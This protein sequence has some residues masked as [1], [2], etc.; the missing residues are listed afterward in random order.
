MG[1]FHCGTRSPIHART[2]CVLGVWPGATGPLQG[3]LL[4][5]P[6]CSGTSQYRCH[7]SPCSHGP[8]CCT[9]DPLGGGS[10]AGDW[11]NTE[12]SGAQPRVSLA[13]SSPS[14]AVLGPGYLIPVLDGVRCAAS[15]FPAGLG[16]PGCVCA[17]VPRLAVPCSAVRV[18]SGSG[19]A[20]SSPESVCGP[21]LLA[22]AAASPHRCRC[23]ARRD[24]AVRTEPPRGLP[25]AA[26]DGF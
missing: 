8:H 24:A 9:M 2:A 7:S 21:A 6:V 18:C 19:S 26:G 12:P 11:G 23:R 16:L 25:Q 17:L 15:L 4:G 10:R 13:L 5:P 14:P 22:V 3:A 1:P 20:L